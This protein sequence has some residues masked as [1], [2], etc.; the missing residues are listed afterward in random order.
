YDALCQP[1]VDEL[2]RRDIDGNLDRRVPRGG[3]AQRLGD[4]LLGQA[5]DH[6]DFLGDRDEDFGRDDAGQRM[7]PAREHLKA[8]DLAGR[9]VHLRFEVRQE[10]AMIEAVVDALLDLALGKERALHSGVEPYRA[11][12][13]TVSRA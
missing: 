3:F 11:R 1:A 13:A 4:D 8:D 5:P 6:A 7:L 10:L 2:R 9:K 12:D